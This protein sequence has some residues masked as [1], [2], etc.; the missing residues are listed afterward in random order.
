MPLANASWSVCREINPSL[1][2]GGRNVDLKRMQKLLQIGVKKTI[3][4]ASSIEIS[5][6]NVPARGAAASMLWSVKACS[7]GLMWQ[8]AGT[9]IMGHPDICPSALVV[10]PELNPKIATA[11]N[12]PTDK[13]RTPCLILL[14]NILR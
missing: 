1:R 8:S 4:S 2:D 5:K 3:E 11:R 7:S 13:V 12:A 10:I 14:L 6:A 9:P